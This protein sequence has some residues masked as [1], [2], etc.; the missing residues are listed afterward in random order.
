MS[1]NEDKRI[2][3]QIVAGID[4]LVNMIRLASYEK[5]KREELLSRGHGVVQEL[6]AL[7]EKFLGANNHYIM[8]AIR[9]LVKQRLSVDRSQITG[10]FFNILEEMISPKE[11]VPS[12]SV[13][14]NPPFNASSEGIGCDNLQRAISFLFPEAKV[15]K[16]YRFCGVNFEYYIPSCSLAVVDEAKE[17]GCQALKDYLCKSRG[18]RLIRL[19]TQKLSSYREIAR[20]IKWKLR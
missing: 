6:S 5:E 16:N 14:S 12:F 19:N 3:E 1:T 4:V 20:H 15:L 8:Q 10:D 7:L 2:G 18:I 13:G 9:E 11:D 17:K